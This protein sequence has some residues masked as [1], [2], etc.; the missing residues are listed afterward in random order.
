MGS[1]VYTVEKNLIEINTNWVKIVGEQIRD[2]KGQTL[3][4]WRVE[5]DN[6]LIVIPF[7]KQQF[8]LPGLVYRHGIN[9][10]TYDFPGGRIPRDG[11]IE[12]E[13]AI[14]LEREIGIG[15]DKIQD[16]K[17]LNSVG[18]PINSAFSNQ[19]LFCTVASI[20][21]SLNI[22]DLQDVQLFPRS[23]KGI[24]E[25]RKNLS[26]LQCRAALLEWCFGNDMKIEFSK[27]GG[28]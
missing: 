2:E 18:W 24:M 3:D 1:A 22:K 10:K 21:E 4:Y 27:T 19:E 25:L 7:Y 5:K 17:Q 6:S 9:R 12:M 11:N 16:I 15:K 13:S 14:I 28:I 20:S 23:K 26:C 8:M